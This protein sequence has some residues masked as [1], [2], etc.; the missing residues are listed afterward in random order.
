MTGLLQDDSQAKASLQTSEILELVVLL[1]DTLLGVLR[2]TSFID[3]LVRCDIYL[4]FYYFL[5]YF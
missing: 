5:K 3:V 2:L 4:Y 1:R